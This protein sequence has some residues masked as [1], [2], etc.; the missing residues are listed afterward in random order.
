MDKMWDLLQKIAT[1]F[2]ILGVSLSGMMNFL[3]ARLGEGIDRIEASGA[4][5]GRKGGG[6]LWSVLGGIF[7][8]IGFFVYL[9]ITWFIGDAIFALTQ[10]DTVEVISMIILWIL[11]VALIGEFFG[12]VYGRRL[13]KR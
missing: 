8:Y 12:Y 2:S 3:Y 6:C 7:L 13:F 9:V 10:D 4:L 11:P 1:I 5:R